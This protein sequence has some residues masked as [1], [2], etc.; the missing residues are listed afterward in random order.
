MKT[1]SKNVNYQFPILISYRTDR[2]IDGHSSYF[3]VIIIQ[4]SKP[5]E[6]KRDSDGKQISCQTYFKSEKLSNLLLKRRSTGNLIGNQ[7]VFWKYIKF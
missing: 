4:D 6:R 2:L 7:K 5:C 3:N 1:Y